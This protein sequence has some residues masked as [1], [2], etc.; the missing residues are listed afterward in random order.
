M[1]AVAA[2]AIVCTAHAQAPSKVARVAV[3]TNGTVATNGHLTDAFVRGLAELGYVEGRNV[4]FDLRYAE[5]QLDRLPV[6]VQEIAARKPDLVFAP[7]ALAANAVRKGG[8]TQ[9]SSLP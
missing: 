2:I 8:V 7:S 6:L 9:P 3:L 4:E 1:L 5:G